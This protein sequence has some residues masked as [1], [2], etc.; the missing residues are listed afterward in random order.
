MSALATGGQSTGNIMSAT[1]PAPINAANRMREARVA[2]RRN[3]YKSPSLRNAAPA[4]SAPP[5]T[6][7]RCGGTM[8]AGGKFLAELRF[9][10]NAL[11]GAGAAGG[12]AGPRQA[13]AAGFDQPALR[14][15]ASGSIP[16]FLMASEARAEARNSISRLE[17]SVPPEPATTAAENT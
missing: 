8:S 11:A 9:L 17:L 13:R 1:A 2:K 3:A 10:L 12:P 14:E 6:H 7:Y 5:I 16:L 4:R 15:L